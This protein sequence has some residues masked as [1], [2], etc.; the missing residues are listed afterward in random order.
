MRAFLVESGV[1]GWL[2]GRRVSL[3]TVISMVGF[4]WVK[5]WREIFW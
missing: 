1:E 5:C 3:K 4:R 2:K